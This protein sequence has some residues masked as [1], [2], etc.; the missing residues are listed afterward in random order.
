MK[1]QKIAT[2][3]C[4][5]GKMVPVTANKDETC[6]NCGHYVVWEVWE[7]GKKV[8]CSNVPNYE[9][10]LLPLHLDYFKVN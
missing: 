2:C 4:G 7:G 5:D 8:K 1:K 10:E 9:G 6:A 3:N